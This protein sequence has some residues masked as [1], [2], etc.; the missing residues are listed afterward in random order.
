MDFYKLEEYKFSD[1]ED[2]INNEVEE[3]LHLD[4]KSAGSLSKEDKKKAEIT[5]MFP[6]LQIQMVALLLMVYRKSII[7]QILLVLLMEMRLQ[8]NG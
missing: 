7:S 3:N 8:K 5:M 1:L 4:Y 6:L 2:L